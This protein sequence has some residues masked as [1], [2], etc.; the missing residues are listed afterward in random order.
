M[1][2]VLLTA[3][4]FINIPVKSI[5]KAYT[6]RVP[7]SLAFLKAGWRVCIPFGGRKVEGFVTEVADRETLAGT[8]LKDIISAVDEE[9]WFSPLMMSV[10]AW[11]A[12]FY[13]CSLGEAMRLFM[14][15]KSGLQIKAVYKADES[16]KKHRL[17][18]AQSMQRVYDVLAAGSLGL[19][20]LK[21]ALPDMSADLPGI[22][23]RLCHYKII[24]KDYE[25][26]RREQV[27]YEKI[28]RLLRKPAAENEKYF[29]RRPAQ[30]RLL[31]IMSAQGCCPWSYLRKTGITAATVQTLADSGWVAIE[32]RRLLRDSYLVDESQPKEQVQLNVWQKKA[33]SAMQPYLGSNSYRRFLL[34]GVTGSGKTQVY[35][36]AA[37]L[38][39]QLGR[40][41]IVLVPEIALT[42]QVVQAFQK[43]FPT[44]IIVMHS[45]LSL[46]ERNDAVMRLRRKKA[47]IVI[48]ARSAL[49]MPLEDIGLIIM[50]EEQ[51]M[52]YKQDE[53][54][55]YQARQVAD[56]MARQAGAVLL[57]G[58]ATPSLESFYAAQDGDST[59][60]SLPERIGGHPLPTIIPVDMRQ[61]MKMGNRHIVSRVL[62]D[63][64]TQTLAAGE[65]MIIMLNRRGYS[66]FIMCRSCGYVV[67]CQECGL[68]MVYHKDGRLSCHNCDIRADIPDV[69][70][71]CGSRYIK[72]FGSGT[73]K[74][75]QELSQ[76]MPT[77]KVIRM[78]RDTTA[79][80]FAHSK[81]LR[82]FRRHEYDILLGT[83]MVAKGHDIPD[84]T[85]VGI[86]SADSCLNMPDFR[87]AERCFMLI[88]QTAGRAGR[89]N[90]PGRVV[91]QTYDPDHYA[92][93]AAVQQDYD[94]F[95]AEELENRRQLFYPPFSRLVKLIFQA[96][97]ESEALRM[98]Q[99]AAD[100][101]KRTFQNKAGFKAE[102][103]AP[104]TAAQVRGIY[105]FCLLLKTNNLDA[106][107]CFLR[108]EKL[109]LRTNVIVDIDPLQIL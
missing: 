90:Q 108:Q 72:Y 50:D 18:Q 27:K 100:S 52:S 37:A 57:L 23:S 75:E 82:S 81:I 107:R 4:I 96:A 65:Q 54:P 47:G 98:S 33:L 7:D 79:A 102:G 61:E 64:L 28:V 104:A 31:A 2:M 87:A 101:F 8:E 46:A 41:V 73:E 51:D 48:G 56:E 14:P 35:I 91:V 6:Y 11:L 42:G 58:S 89:G 99:E 60:L 53:S 62:A 25:T 106:L 84:V 59:L 10:A 77:A 39:R 44:D 67:K 32:K 92:V 38:V 78:D 29:Q 66:T 16:Q 19:S 21:K 71:S 70:P 43:V 68:P 34:Y 1:V 20:A 105:R 74:L 76:L 94:V 55:R 9:A 22:L 45:R 86:I 63:M 26:H 85:A 93:R 49:F 80:K 109:H 30:R 95:Y 15:G 88:T 97:D 69:C 13:L 40:P 12:D 83:Q 5:A 103:P 24:C 17:L 36:E 3:D